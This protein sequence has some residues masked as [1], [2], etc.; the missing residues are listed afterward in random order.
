MK[1]GDSHKITFTNRQGQTL[2]ARLDLPLET[3]RAYAL[4]AHCFT[5]SKDIFAA[6]RIAQGLTN[7]DIAVLRFDFT[8]LGASEGEFANSNFSSNVE[9]LEDAARFLAEEYESPALLIG[10]SLGGAAV[11]VAAPRLESVQ[12]VATINAPADPDHVKENF[13]YA[14]PEIQESGA[15]QVTL[16]GRPFTIKRQ[17]L[18]DIAQQRLADEIATMKKALLVFHAPLD[19]QVGIEN[20]AKI[21]KAAKHPKSFI[22]LDQA[23]HLL[24]DRQDAIYVA[25]LL[26]SWA[27]RYLPAPDS[28]IHP[29]DLSEGEVLVQENGVGRFSQ[30]ISVGGRHKLLADEPPRI[31][32]T[33]TGPTPYDLLLSGLGA[34]TTMTMRMYAQRKG[35]SLDRAK[36]TLRHEKIHAD[37]CESCES[38]G[39]KI[40]RIERRIELIGDLSNKE[41]AKLL[42]IADK[43]PV[44]RTLH[45]EVQ[46]NSRL[47]DD[48]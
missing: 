29:E 1:R 34:C 45:S 16:A 31:G 26:G 48:E 39:G 37:D 28:A 32:G 30:T 40:D 10:H 20:A 47:A 14:L 33:D 27:R 17:F 6:S 18:E 13:H 36:V 11:L 7:N 21:F 22:S 19:Q 15:A 44:H 46:I 41:R 24:S 3:P 2:A 25:D 5:C 9:D 12:A 8:G 43:C 42:E 38:Q 35:L 4:F 23:D